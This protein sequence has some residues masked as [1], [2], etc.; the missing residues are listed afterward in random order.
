M[1]NSYQGKDCYDRHSQVELTVV[2]AWWPKDI[3]LPRIHGLTRICQ[4]LTTLLSTTVSKSFAAGQEPLIILHELFLSIY[5]SHLR[6]IITKCLFFVNRDDLQRDGIQKHP[7][8]LPYIH[9]VCET[10]SSARRAT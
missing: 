2:S 6:S 7:G 10:N 3:R 1:V 9:E 4:L 8:L 5:S